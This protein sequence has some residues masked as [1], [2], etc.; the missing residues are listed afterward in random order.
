M[1][2]DRFLHKRAGHGERSGRLSHLEWRVWTVYMLAADD[3]GVMWCD[4]APIVT[5]CPKL[6]EER[7][8][9]IR[10]ALEQII[11]STLVGRFTHQGRTYIYQPDWQ[12]FQ[13][14]EWPQATTL[15]P[16]PP[17]HLLKCTSATQRLMSVW[18]GQLRV[19]SDPARQKKSRDSVASHS[20]EG[21]EPI[22]S[23]LLD[24]ANGSGYGYG[25]GSGSRSSEESARE[26]N[27]AD[28][29]PEWFWSHWRRLMHASSG[30]DLPLTPTPIEFSK[31]V[32]AIE[33]VAD[34]ETLLGAIER[35]MHLS[36]EQARLLNVKAKTVGYFVMALPRLL[37]RDAAFGTTSRTAGN[38]AA[39]AAF[40]SQG[41]KS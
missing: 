2:A 3:F 7:P 9:S 38:A 8:A 27:S 35:F 16:L 19:P 4:P 31:V 12:D 6:G 5:A 41:P 14:I 22:A 20:Q 23:E 40:V 15:P 25:N 33:R 32:A 39:L 21:S 1:P 24:R 28:G 30:I 13:K 29:R 34:D 36:D 26:I 18:P 37:Q 11:T 10:K 17:D